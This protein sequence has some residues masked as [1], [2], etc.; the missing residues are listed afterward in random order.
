MAAT[1]GDVASTRP[2]MFDVAGR[3]K[4][5]A[6]AALRGLGRDDAR[7]QYVALADRVAVP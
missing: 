6:H 5:D 3:A 7:Q 1:S 2:G 4:W